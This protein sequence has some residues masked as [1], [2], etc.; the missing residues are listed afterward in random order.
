M[1]G[2]RVPTALILAVGL[3]LALGPAAGATVSKEQTATHTWHVSVRA[4]AQFN[5]T[6]AELRFAGQGTSP[7]RL[8]LTRAPGH[9]YVAGALVRK[10]TSDGPRALVVIVNKRPRG[11]TAADRTMIGLHVTGDLKLGVPRV[12]E[13]VNAFSGAVGSSS[14]GLCALGRNH[15]SAYLSKLLGAGRALP[16]FS[17]TAAAA[18]AY[19]VACGLPHDPAFGKVITGCTTAL[20]SGG[21]CPADA[22]CAS[23]PTP[24]PTPAPTPVPPPTPTPAPTPTPT[25]TPVPTPTCPCQTPVCNAAPGYACPDADRVIACPLASPEIAC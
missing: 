4:P 20:V 6:F 11:S 7:L 25:P 23:P 15:G 17:A 24:S 18:E 13:L 12:R 16:G 10:P 8:S 19:D 1:H 2:R 3:M 5:L 22:M 14:T 21:C 9:Y